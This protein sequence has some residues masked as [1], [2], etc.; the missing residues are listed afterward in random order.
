MSIRFKRGT[1][2][3]IDS[4]ASKGGLLSGE[5]LFIT[6]ENRIAIATS[7]SAY[8]GMVKQGEV[9][10]VAGQFTSR[11]SNA[12]NY[13]PTL[14]NVYFTNNITVDTN[15]ARLT[16]SIA[17]IYMVHYQQL[18][19]TTG[20]SCYFSIRKNGVVIAHAYSDNDDTYDITNT[21][22]V[23]LQAGDYVDFYYDGTTVF[24]WDNL[25]SHFFMHK[26]S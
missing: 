16:V 23:S 13:N 26:I 24:T 21:V 25:H 5:P 8:Q 6:D 3:A 22:L 14:T 2:A 4:V 18:V 15:L 11:T 17:G 12:T 20:F 9:P 19:R 1:K 10:Y 7:N